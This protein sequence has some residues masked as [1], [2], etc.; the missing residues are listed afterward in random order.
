MWR[1]RS[2]RHEHHTS[3]ARCRVANAWKRDG[4]K[5]GL[6]AAAR[7]LLAA[8]ADALAPNH[9]GQTPWLL[10]SEAGLGELQQLMQPS[11][12]SGKREGAG[13]CG[14][15]ARGWWCCTEGL[16]E[17]CRGSGRLAG[18]DSKECP[19]DPCLCAAATLKLL[20]CC[21]AQQRH[22]STPA[23]LG[24]GPRFLPHSALGCLPRHLHTGIARRCCRDSTRPPSGRRHAGAALHGGWGRHLLCVSDVS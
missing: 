2:Q 23:R 8:G 9:A 7:A 13:C 14:A 18:K 15:L 21:R 4:S 20:A 11:V 12:Q 5:E 19:D 3:C 24:R 10:A 16:G 6:E 17:V 1:W 22:G